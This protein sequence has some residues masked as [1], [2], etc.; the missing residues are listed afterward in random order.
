MLPTIILNNAVSESELNEIESD[1]ENEEKLDDIIKQDK[2]FRT[3]PYRL[4]ILFKE[5]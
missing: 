4:T 2:A 1:L 3:I 5:N